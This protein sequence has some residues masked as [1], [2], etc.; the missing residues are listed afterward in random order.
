MLQAEESWPVSG[1]FIVEEAPEELLASLRGLGPDFETRSGAGLVEQ[2]QQL[3]RGELDVLVPPLGCPVVA[4]DEPHPMQATEVAVDKR[5]PRF[6]LLRCTVGEA[7]MPL[8]VLVPAVRGEERVLGRGSGLN[9]APVAPQD[10]LASLN[11]PLR[12]SDAPF[13]DRVGRHTGILTDD[14]RDVARSEV[15][16]SSSLRPMNE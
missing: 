9:R 11:Q 4:G 16:A 8:R 5:V 14:S 6:G 12:A 3:V 2:L 10:V 13:V 7:E 15:M 1:H